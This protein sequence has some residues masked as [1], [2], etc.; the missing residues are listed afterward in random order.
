MQLHYYGIQ[1]LVFTH[2]IGFTSATAQEIM[3]QCPM[4]ETFVAPSITAKD[5][6]EGH[7]WVCLNLR[8]LSLKFCFHPQTVRRMQPLVFER[9]SKLTRL[10]ELTLGGSLSEDAGQKLY[11]VCNLTLENGLDRLSTLRS[12]RVLDIIT[13]RQGMC[14]KEI[15]WVMEHWVSLTDIYGVLNVNT[16]LKR[17]LWDQGIAFHGY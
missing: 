10:E 2:P 8:V 16:E 11:D 6:I 13:S 14:E 12:L 4:L 3:C 15:E 9:L 1:K 7:P 17:R 5:I